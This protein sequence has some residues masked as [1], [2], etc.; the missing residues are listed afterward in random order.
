MLILKKKRL[1][2]L[3]LPLCMI[4]AICG[5]MVISIS[6]SRE[7]NGT[8]YDIVLF[9]NAYGSQIDWM[10]ILKRYREIRADLFTATLFQI[11]Q[12]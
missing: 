7:L 4:V 1:I 11:G 5:S 2:I 10:R 6:K 9:A 12:K 3:L 8:L